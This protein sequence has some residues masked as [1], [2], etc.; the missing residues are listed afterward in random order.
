MTCPA[1]TCLL[2]NV[3]EARELNVVEKLPAGD[4]W[5]AIADRLARAEA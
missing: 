3:D 2:G 1:Y 5:T 4:D